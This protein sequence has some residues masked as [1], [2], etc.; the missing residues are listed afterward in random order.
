MLKINRFIYNVQYVQYVQIHCECE[1]HT[2]NCIALKKRGK[3]R[4]SDGI[5]FK[6]CIK[7]IH[8]RGSSIRISLLLIFYA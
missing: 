2:Y 7:K 5:S 1:Q 8:Y 6:G 3:Y 4:Y